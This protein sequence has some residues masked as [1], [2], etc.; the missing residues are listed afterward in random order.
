MKKLVLAVCCLLS[1][2]LS[3]SQNVGIGTTTPNTS[4]A[5]DIT[6][7]NKG[8]LPPRVALTSTADVSTITSPTAGLL[9][10]NTATAGTAPTNVVPGYYYYTGSSWLRISNAGNAAGDMQYWNGSQWV[11]IPA[12]ATGLTLTMCSGVPTWGPCSGGGGTLATVITGSISNVQGTTANTG[13]NVTADGGAP[14]TARGICYSRTLNPTIADTTITNATGG[15]G[16][17]SSFMTNLAAST[18]YHIRAFATNTAGTAYGSDSSFTTT[19]ITA[20]VL[21]TTTAF[22]IGSTTASSGGT[23]TST[24]GTPLSARG[25]VY[26]TSTGPTLANSVITDGGTTGG[27]YT[28]ILTGLTA[29]TTYYVRAYA[30]NTLGTTYGNEISFTTLAAGYFAANYTFDSVKTTSGLTDPSPLPVVPGLTFGAFTAVG[31]GA[32]SLNS[33][34]PFRFSLTD[35]TLGATN[36]SDVFPQEDTTTK[37]FEVTI[38]PNPGKTLNLGSLSFRWQRSG[39]GARQCFVRSSRDG[40]VNNL[41]ASIN[42]A[43]ANLSVVTGNKFQMVDGVTLAQDGCTITPTGFINITAPVTFRFYGINAE[44]VSGT[45]S[46]DN[47]VFNGLVQ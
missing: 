39:T 35:W 31:A 21:T 38:T 1:A 28:S 24:G 3:F 19:A 7:T 41:A 22:G 13:G 23:I 8:L 11:L 26:K 34:A 12:G 5:L 9:V 4:A 6:A 42:P 15:T 27:S 46:L 2:T 47:V 40:Y 33:T 45:F 18:T 17:F 32:P 14:V 44:A 25:I 37:Y 20:P 30:T 10:Y 16:T 36:G 29:N 43:N